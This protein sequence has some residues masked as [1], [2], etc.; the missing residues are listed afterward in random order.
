MSVFIA[1]CNKCLLAGGLLLNESADYPELEWFILLFAEGELDECP[2]FPHFIYLKALHPLR[3][4]IGFPKFLNISY[5]WKSYI[6]G[7]M[8]VNVLHYVLEAFLL[9]LPLHILFHL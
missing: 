1:I 7:E 9:L 5:E 2:L 8:A 3:K 4:L 6:L